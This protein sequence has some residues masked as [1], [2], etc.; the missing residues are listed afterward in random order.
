MESYGKKLADVW[1]DLQQTQ[2]VKMQQVNETTIGEFTRR[3]NILLPLTPADVAVW[4]FVKEMYLHNPKDFFRYITNAGLMHY[5]ILVG[6]GA[7]TTELNLKELIT[8][9]LN[10]E[11]TKFIVSP[12]NPNQR[13]RGGRNRGRRNE[14]SP[15]ASKDRYPAIPPISNDV[16]IS[17][18]RRQSNVPVI[19]PVSSTNV[20]TPPSGTS[21]AEMVKSHIVAGGCN[22]KPQTKMNIET[23]DDIPDK[24]FNW[25]DEE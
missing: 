23:F 21:Y 7:M 8:V 19:V 18:L 14:R 24:Q 9:R 13:V 16:C 5:T 20:T 3:L 4:S 10:K 17:I 1:S 2:L 11:R 22:A 25:G 12:Y 15:P 6:G